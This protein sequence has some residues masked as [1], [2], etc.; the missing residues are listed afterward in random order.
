[1]YR[2]LLFVAF[3]R[4]EADTD[5]V[6]DAKIV[7]MVGETDDSCITRPLDRVVNDYC[8]PDC[9]GPIIEVKW[10]N[11]PDVKIEIAN[12]NDVECP[13]ISVKVSMCCLPFYHVY[14]CSVVTVSKCF[15]SVGF[16]RFCRKNLGFRF[17]LG[18]HDKRVVNFM[19]R[20]IWHD[21]H[22]H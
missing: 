12:E 9:T 15:L 13:D 10:D 17:G 14:T 20:V 1:V 6:E 7:T 11:F 19:T 21:F 2:I 22:H 5:V 8:T 4:T 18:F 3:Y 16:G